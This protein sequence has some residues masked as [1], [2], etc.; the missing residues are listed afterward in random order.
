MT[1]KEL[2]KKIQGLRQVKP[3]EDWVVFAK[4]EILGPA[5]AEAT[6]GKEQ[7]TYGERISAVLDIFPRIIFSVG[8]GQR[9]L[10]Y[11]TLTIAV[12][13]VGVFGFA[14]HTVPGDL[15]FPLKKITENSQTVFVSEQA[16][17]SHDF[18][19]VNKRMDDLI[20]ADESNQ[21]KKIASAV[22]EVR[23]SISQVAKNLEKIEEP[24]K[25]IAAIVEIRKIEKKQE[26]LKK[27]F[28]SQAEPEEEKINS[29]Q[30][31]YK[32]PASVLI[33]SLENLEEGLYVE[34]KELL[35]EAGV[36]FE[37]GNYREALEKVLQI[38]S[39]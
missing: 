14:Q 33:R 21:T 11:A 12:V 19:I 15:L 1:E 2:I 22:N 28:A 37:N 30:E 36:D 25:A 7:P 34:Q 31:L 35:N 27:V 38:Q 9:K 32:T 24:E 17:L 8:S 39:H 10:A 20:R 5:F 6:A 26:K 23:E 4:K 16:Q 13:L 3:R 18:E 29:V